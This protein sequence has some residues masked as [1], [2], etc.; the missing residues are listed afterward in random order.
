LNVT[1]VSRD[2]KPEEAAK[3]GFGH[4]RTVQ[5]ALVGLPEHLKGAKVA[6]FPAGGITLPLREKAY[7]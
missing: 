5:K 1:L 3:L 4:A 7:F 2:V 6:I